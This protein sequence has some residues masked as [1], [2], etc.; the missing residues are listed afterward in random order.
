MKDLRRDAEPAPQA[1]A[2]DAQERLLHTTRLAVA[3]VEMTRDEPVNAV[4]AFNVRVE[5]IQ[6][7]APDFDAPSLRAHSPPAH[8]HFNEDRCAPVVAHKLERQPRRVN[9]VV[10]FLLPTVAA[11]A[12]PKVTVMIEQADGDER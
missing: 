10:M 3:A 12:L 8:L 2:A 9:L 1:H 4:V 11:Q 5:Q 6:V 7:H